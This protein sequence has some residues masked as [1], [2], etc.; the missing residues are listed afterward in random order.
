MR[1][2][3]DDL[4]LHWLRIMLCTPAASVPMSPV[5]RI[6]STPVTVLCHCCAALNIRSSKFNAL[7]RILHALIVQLV[8][9]LISGY[10]SQPNEYAYW[11]PEQY[12]EGQ[13]PRDLDGTLFRNG[14]PG[15]KGNV[16][17]ARTCVTTT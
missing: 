8:K 13:I 1:C 7:T 12:I 15:H 16:C 17:E 10:V 3:L 9:S 14:E 4:L 11:L 2:V 5:C 6:Y